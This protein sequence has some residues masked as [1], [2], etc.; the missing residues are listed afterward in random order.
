MASGPGNVIVRRP[1]EDVAGEANILE[2]NADRFLEIYKEKHVGG[3]FED[4]RVPL[5]ESVKQDTLSELVRRYRSSGWLSV[6]TERDSHG[7]YMVLS[8]VLAIVIPATKEEMKNRDPL[9]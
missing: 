7:T 2:K 4:I 6:E 8:N 3:I 5:G 1:V 9:V